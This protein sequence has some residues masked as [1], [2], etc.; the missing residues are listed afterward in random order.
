[1]SN[2]SSPSQKPTDRIAKGRF[3]PGNKL[4]VRFQPGQSSNP[5][6]SPGTQVRVDVAYKKLIALSPD[7]FRE[8]KPQ[9]IAEVMAP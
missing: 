3:A 5:G 6:G 2:A 7:E 9:T 8:F 1:M 4:G